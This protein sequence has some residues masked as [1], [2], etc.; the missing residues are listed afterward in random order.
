[1]FGD[2]GRKKRKGF[3]RSGIDEEQKTQIE[4]RIRCHKIPG[5]CFGVSSGYSFLPQVSYTERGSLVRQTNRQTD[6]PV[7]SEGKTWENNQGSDRGRS[8]QTGGSETRLLFLSCPAEQNLI[9]YN[10]I[11]AAENA[12]FTVNWVEYGGMLFFGFGFGRVYRV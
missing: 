6:K 11:M 3:W 4:L 5:W 1:M 12:R 10:I 2:R 8:C 7:I 9:L